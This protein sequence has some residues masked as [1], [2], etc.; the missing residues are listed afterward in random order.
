LPSKFTTKI[1]DLFGCDLRSLALLRIACGLLVL[2]DLVHRAQDI[3]AHYSDFGVLPRTALI[4]QM[5]SRWLVSINLISGTW[6]VQAVL[7]LVG[8]LFALALTVGY[9]TRL[10]TIGCWFFF[11][12]LNVRNPLL[13]QA[14]DVE[15][16]VILFWC[17]FL[18]WGARYS[19]DKVLH[20][21]WDG[22]PDRC[23]SWA[24][25][26]YLLQIVFIYWF[27]ALLKTGPEWRVEG[28]AVYYALS[29]DQFATSA[30]HFLL[31]FPLL[32]KIVTFGVYGFE[33]LG[34]LLLFSPIYTGPIRTMVVLGFFLMHIGFGIGL[35][36]GIFVW[37]GALCPIG[38]LPAWFWEH[39]SIRL[40]PEATQPLLVYYDGS[41]GFCQNAVRVIRGFLSAGEVEFLPASGD[42]M[43]ATEMEQNNSWVVVEPQG[44]K[45][46]K[47][48]GV[49]ILAKQ[50]WFLKYL[51]P[52][53]SR[54]WMARI[55]NQVYSLVAN[56]RK[57]VCSLEIDRGMRRIPGLKLSKG[58]SVL[59]IVLLAYVFVWNLTTLRGRSLRLGE[60]QRLIGE[61]LGLEQSWDMFAPYP[62]KEDGWYVIPGKLKNGTE[63][64][65]FREGKPVSWAKP[66]LVSATFKNFRWRKYMM[67]LWRPYYK[68]Q[69]VYYAQY[70]CRDWNARHQGTSQLAELE[71]Y[72][73]LE[74]TLPDYEYSTPQKILMLKHSCDEPKKESQVGTVPG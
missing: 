35:A 24:T 17:I 28:S 36:I 37:I 21:A 22:A 8:G 15:L 34:P 59:V 25:V 46:F 23:L 11:L 45:H 13:L 4:E 31:D 39:L 66:Q 48:D 9:K 27:G 40:H 52:I 62:L 38:L 49:L 63:V 41:C 61:I 47:Y 56:H 53:L 6:A 70:L 44:Q 19:I 30:G 14:G 55:G 7:F 43:I 68:N 57:T 29:I 5:Y 42:P 32:L 67:N 2:V 3:V 71:I 74:I 54:R 50:S 26:A 10:A 73:M 20:P 33:I 51:T 64:D 16:R 58:G 69:R 18:P 1:V 12:S 60:R 72:F 65:L